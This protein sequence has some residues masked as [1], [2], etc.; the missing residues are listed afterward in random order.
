MKRAIKWVSLSLAA[1]LLALSLLA[2]TIVFRPFQLHHLQGTAQEVS[3]AGLAVPSFSMQENGDFRLIQVNDTHLYNGSGKTDS[4]TLADLRAVLEKEK[5]ALVIANGDILDGIN[6]YL[7]NNKRRAA[8]AF[9][10]LMEDLGIYWAYVPGNNDG[11]TLGS[12]RDVTAFFS[13]YPHCIVANEKDLTGA[14]QFSIPLTDAEDETVHT[15][16]LLDSLARDAKRQYDYIK[17]DQLAWLKRTLDA[18]NGRPVSLFFHMDTPGFLTAR[19]GG[20]LYQEGYAPI[21]PG[22]YS[23]IPKNTAVDAVIAEAKNIGLVSIGHIHPDSNWCNF[24]EGRYYHVARAAGYEV[25]PQ[26]GVTAIT[27]HTAQSDS[28]AMYDFEDILYE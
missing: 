25:T 11:E 21:A 23:G 4:K 26:P 15:L 1:L 5:P 6:Y 22:M 2:V 12:E 18:Q 28:R 7:H 24:F 8:E 16:I 17:D 14:T 20:V 13:Q 27:I 3:V 10:Q 9:A 19:D